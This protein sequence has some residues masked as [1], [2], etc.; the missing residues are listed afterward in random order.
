M[1]M[2]IL[3]GLGHL[4]EARQQSW[5]CS[6]IDIEQQAG[7]RKELDSGF[8]DI[9]GPVR[10][11]AAHGMDDDASNDAGFGDMSEVARLLKAGAPAKPGVNGSWCFR[12]QHSGNWRSYG[13]NGRPSSGKLV[14]RQA[15]A[16]SGWSGCSRGRRNFHTF[17]Q[18]I[19]EHSQAQIVVVDSTS[20]QSISAPF[21]PSHRPGRRW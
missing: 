7:V 17:I 16:H 19:E 6:T 21:P 4:F 18:N 1:G 3:D 10:E 2:S 14:V 8:F 5:F 11:M 15:V 12:A 20:C 13:G 9:F